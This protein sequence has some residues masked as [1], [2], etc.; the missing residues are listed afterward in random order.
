MNSKMRFLMVSLAA[1]LAVAQEPQLRREGR[2]WVVESSGHFTPAPRLQVL[3]PGGNVEVRG[4]AAQIA[5]RAVRRVRARSEAEARRLLAAHPLLTRRVGNLVEL[6]TD[7]GWRYSGVSVDFFVDVP[8]TLSLADLKTAGGNLLV[9]GIDGQA[10]ATTAG[11]NISA[12]RIGAGARLQTAGGNV[13]L[14]MIRGLLEVE[15]AGGLI[16]LKNAAADAI[17]TTHGGDIIAEACEAAVRARTAGGNVRIARA[18]GNVR[19]ETAGGGIYVGEALSQVF[20]ATSGGPIEV[21]AAKSVQA[22]SGAGIIRLWKVA[23]PVRAGTA[24]G[25]ITATLAPDPEAFAESLLESAIG[26]VVVFIPAN[27][28]VDI[29]AVIE[30]AGRQHRILSDFPLALRGGEGSGRHEVVGEGRLNGGG[31]PLRI[32]TTSGNIEIR[33]VKQ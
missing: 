30:G 10:L 12:D 16:S 5:W 23:G 31:K 28:P 17:L 24:A 22:E 29:Q 26:D 4:G 32:R 1:A 27:F 2:Y 11:G 20:A 8:R 33:K 15:T 25:N 7:P 19:A 13:S 9:E 3:S 18:R 21:R 14:G 6:R